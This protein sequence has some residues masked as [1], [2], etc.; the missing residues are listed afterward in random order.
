[1]TISGSVKGTITFNG[2]EIGY[3]AIVSGSYWEDEGDYWTPPSSDSEGPFFEDIDEVEYEDYE[4]HQDEIDALIKEDVEEHKDWDSCDW[5]E[6]E[7]YEPE[8]PEED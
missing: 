8:P 7:P 2:E 4:Q 3:I 1:M 5:D 6:P